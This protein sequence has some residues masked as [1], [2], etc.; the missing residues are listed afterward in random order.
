MPVLDL[1]V[2][3]TELGAGIVF[4][5]TD[6]ASHVATSTDEGPHE[7][8][9]VSASLPSALVDPVYDVV[10]GEVAMLGLDV[11]GKVVLGDV[12][13]LAQGIAGSQLPVEDS[14]IP[15]AGEA[16]FYV[17]R[18]VLL[19]DDSKGTYDPAKCLGG[20][21]GFPGGRRATSGDCGP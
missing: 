13:C 3:R 4:S 16:F 6:P 11:D 15:P 2:G 17:A 7:T 10:R 14:T 18:R 9:E 5:V 21:A 19:T 12:T 1:E 20:L 8:S